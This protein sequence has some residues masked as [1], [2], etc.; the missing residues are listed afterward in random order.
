MIFETPFD[1]PGEIPDDKIY[2]DVYKLLSENDIDSKV[3]ILLTHAP[4]F[5]S[6]ADVIENGAHVGSQ[7]ILKVINEFKPN[8]NLCGHVHE[9]RSISKID[10]ST[11]VANPGMLKD[12]GAVLIDIK[13]N[14]DY[15]IEIISL[16]E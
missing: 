6:Q 15:D 9:A 10:S 11:D 5:N 3:K 8:I 4:P 14:T 12:N 13:N 2:E 1:T 7:G 16:I